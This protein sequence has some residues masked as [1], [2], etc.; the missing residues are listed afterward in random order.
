VSDTRSVYKSSTGVQ[1]P[2]S[3]TG[4][5]VLQNLREAMME[6]LK[7]AYDHG[8]RGTSNLQDWDPLSK[9]RL[10]IAQHI[11]GL[12]NKS[13]R[14]NDAQAVSIPEALYRASDEQIYHEYNRR[15]LKPRPWDRGFKIHSNPT[16]QDHFRSLWEASRGD[17]NNLIGQKFT[18]QVEEPSA[19]PVKVVGVEGLSTDAL[20]KGDVHLP[21]I[22]E[23]Y[24]LR[25]VGALLEIVPDDT[26]FTRIKIDDDVVGLAA[27]E[28]FKPSGNFT[29]AA[30][31][32]AA[33][34][35][36]KNYKFVGRKHK[37][38]KRKIAKKRSRK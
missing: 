7:S 24:V 17:L 8:A 3:F 28:Y 31:Q 5:H 35:L 6:A 14:A 33:D 32:K 2:L 23:G 11:S 13:E 36:D 34:L 30:L 27:G 10:A 22:P 9:A 12:E 16:H 19:P 4:K 20:P 18:V 26:Q 37:P 25:R 38:K 15:G 1:V 29:K 21:P